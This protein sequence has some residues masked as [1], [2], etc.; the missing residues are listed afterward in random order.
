MKLSES[1]IAGQR[2]FTLVEIIVTLVAAGIL[3]I[4]YFHFMGTAMTHSSKS[5]ELVAGEAKAEAVMERII[6]DYVQFTNEYPK[7]TPPVTALQQ[8][9]DKKSTYESD[10]GGTVSMRYI[11]YDSS[12]D[13]S[14]LPLPLT[15]AISNNLRVTVE[16]HGSDFT[17]ILTNTRINANNP[18]VYY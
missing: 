8:I 17:T 15:E 5:V 9:I 1:K 6:A 12:G 18:K 10:L 16:A 2:G 11:T 7:D 3:A 13:I 14:V 4:F